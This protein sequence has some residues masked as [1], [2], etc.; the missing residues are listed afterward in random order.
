MDQTCPTQR[1]VEVS[2]FEN[3]PETSGTALR[4]WRS[5]GRDRVVY[6]HCRAAPTKQHPACSLPAQSGWGPEFR[7]SIR[8]AFLQESTRC[9]SHFYVRGLVLANSVE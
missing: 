9:E 1:G 8:G 7:L 6:R 2:R 3:T 5:R 4:C